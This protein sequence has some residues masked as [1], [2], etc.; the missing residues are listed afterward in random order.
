M[1]VLLYFFTFASACFDSMPKEPGV[2]QFIA[3]SRVNLWLFGCLQRQRRPGWTMT[4]AK[5]GHCVFHYFFIPPFGSKKSGIE[6][7]AR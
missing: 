2:Y 7:A 6:H 4:R 5:Q 1:G 3:V